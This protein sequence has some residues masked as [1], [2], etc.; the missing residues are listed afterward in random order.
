MKIG[1]VNHGPNF[2]VSF[3]GSFTLPTAV[4]SSEMDRHKEH[5]SFHRP[6]LYSKIPLTGHPWD[7]TGA[8]S[9]STYANLSS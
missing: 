7:D 2:S 5:C 6:A 9:H 8:R 1:V 3:K 4:H